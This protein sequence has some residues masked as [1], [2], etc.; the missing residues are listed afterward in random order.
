[1]PDPNKK[2]KAERIQ[3]NARE[4]LHIYASHHTL[5]AAYG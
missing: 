4:L 5:D 1:M 2:K 3:E